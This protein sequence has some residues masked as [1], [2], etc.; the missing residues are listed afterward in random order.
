MRRQTIHAFATASRRGLPLAAVLFAACTSLANAA[1]I[2]VVD[3]RIERDG[4]SALAP[5]FIATLGQRALIA[6][7]GE[8]DIE[9]AMTVVAREGATDADGAFA[10]RIELIENMTVSDARLDVTLG[11]PGTVTLGEREISVLVRE[12][13][14]LAETAPASDAASGEGAPGEAV[15]SEADQGD[16]VPGEDASDGAA[17]EEANGS[18]TGGG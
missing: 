2:Y 7:E 11:R 9:V 1:G 5:T 16:A 18:A 14:P 8:R 15:P 4:A 3:S 17:S 10:V 12:Q 13:A 6:Y